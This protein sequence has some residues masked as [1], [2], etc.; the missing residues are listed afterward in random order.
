MIARLH[1]DAIPCLQSCFFSLC[2]VIDIN[3]AGGVSLIATRCPCKNKWLGLENDIAFF[4]NT[5]ELLLA[6]VGFAST[7]GSVTTNALSIEAQSQVLERAI[8]PLCKLYLVCTL[9]YEQAKAPCQELICI[10]LQRLGLAKFLDHLHT[11]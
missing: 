10:S 8:H 9:C 7:G 2:E 6:I 4:Q 3:T 5:S 11:F 1:C